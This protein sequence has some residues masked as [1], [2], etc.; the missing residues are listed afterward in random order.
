MILILRNGQV[1]V[2]GNCSRDLML[3][4]GDQIL[5][6][7]KISRDVLSAIEIDHLLYVTTS[8]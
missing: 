1:V 7:I 4:Q 3:L 8:Y 6:S 5:K 2:V